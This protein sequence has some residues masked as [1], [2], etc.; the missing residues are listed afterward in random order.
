MVAR[1]CSLLVLG[2]AFLGLGGVAFR[3]LVNSSSDFAF[4]GVYVLGPLVVV[5]SAALLVS[6][7]R[8][9]FRKN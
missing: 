4:G 2:L 3:Q 1:G 7:I 9:W 8:T 6:A 5:A